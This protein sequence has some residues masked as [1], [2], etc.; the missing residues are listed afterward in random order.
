MQITASIARNT[1]RTQ[2]RAGR[3]GGIRRPLPLL[4][5][6]EAPSPTLLSAFPLPM[7]PSRPHFPRGRRAGPR[8]HRLQDPKPL[9]GPRLRRRR[10]RLTALRPPAPARRHQPHPRPARAPPQPQLRLLRPRLRRPHPPPLPRRPGRGGRGG[11][12]Q[13]PSAGDGDD[14]PRRGGGGRPDLDGSGL[15]ARGHRCRRSGDRRRGV[16]AGSGHRP[17]VREFPRTGGDQLP[18]GVR[19]GGPSR[20][21]AGVH[22]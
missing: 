15:A 8:P 7:L 22:A 6:L 19:G 9:G 14:P 1:N 20:A 3:H 2:S 11:A 12:W 17:R 16:A 18:R 21:R 4:R 10:R 5:R 13:D